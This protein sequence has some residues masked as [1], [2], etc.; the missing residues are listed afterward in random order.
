MKKIIL[1]ISLYGMLFSN[2]AFA[3][4]TA[5][6]SNQRGN[7]CTSV[8][9]CLP[10]ANA[11]NSEAQLK[12]GEVYL[13]AMQANKIT[14][15]DENL[16]NIY[17]WFKKPATE[18][19]AKAQF[20]LGMY[21]FGIAN[22]ANAC[23]ET[24]EALPKVPKEQ[25]RVIIGA[26]QSVFNSST[27][28]DLYNPQDIA[29]ICLNQK[30]K[31]L[32]LAYYYDNAFNWFLKAANQNDSDAQVN[33]AMMYSNGV[34]VDQDNAKAV[35]WFVRAADLGNDDAESNLGAMYAS[36]RYFT[37][38]YNMAFYWFNKSAEHGNPQ[39]QAQLA[40]LYDQGL[41]IPKDKNQA[42]KWYKASAQQGMPDSQATVG[43]ML[44]ISD[45]QSLPTLMEAYAWLNVAIAQNNDDSQGLDYTEIKKL[46][47]DIYS[48][49]TEAQKKQ[50]DE[51]SHKY[52]QRYVLGQKIS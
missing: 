19:F 49:F 4:T 14:P 24:M 34:G 47:D 30:A 25:R 40:T 31:N 1:L 10:L 9:S 17:S 33:L 52:W 41:G 42:L 36:G 18:G 6:A 5:P 3:K 11:G 38:N 27:H 13:Q 2:C 22:R 45:N 37:Q 20:H 50:A 12:L 51:L 26:I 28:Y 16:N 7:S 23:E 39:G 8:E 43:V 32:I 29:T 35:R 48:Q 46:R 21:Y 15:T 44:A